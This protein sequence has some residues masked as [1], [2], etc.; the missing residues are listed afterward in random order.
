MIGNNAMLVELNISLWTARKMDK[1]VSEEVDSAKGT[2]ARAGNYNKK[3]LAGSNKL[4]R[5]QQVASA[6]RHWH[7]SNTLPWSDTGA[8]LL[9][10]KMFFD[11][12][13]KL[14]EFNDEYEQAV[15]EFIVEYPQLVSAA[16]FTLNDLFARD[17]YPDVEKI[18]GKF[19]FNYSFSPVPDA[20]DFRVQVEDEALAELKAQYEQHYNAKLTDAMKEAWQRLHDVLSHMSERLDFTDENKKKFY[21]STITNASE[22]CEMLTKLNVTNDPKLEEARKKLERA[23]VGVDADGVKESQELRQSVKSKVDEILSMF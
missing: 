9:P 3:L 12:K 23:L 13:T 8:R 17:E 18:A 5:I 6:A 7:L 11:Y 1:K 10:M 2:R 22:L 21:A 4:D 19:R 16:A 20:G 15:N 14:N